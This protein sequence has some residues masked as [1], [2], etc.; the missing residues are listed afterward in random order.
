[1][2]IPPDLR[3]FMGQPNTESNPSDTMQDEGGSIGMDMD[4][5][6]EGWE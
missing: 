5:D 4:D 3:D 6:A 1:M 2:N